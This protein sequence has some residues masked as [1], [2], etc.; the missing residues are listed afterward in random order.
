EPE[1]RYKENV[2][3]GSRGKPA[4]VVFKD[5]ETENDLLHAADT[6]NEGNMTSTEIGELVPATRLLKKK[7][8]K[9]NLH[10]PLGNRVVFDDEGNKLPPLATIAD[11]QSC[12]G[13]SLFDPGMC[14]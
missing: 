4:T 10:R 11:P 6:S 8:L 2:L 9:I 12:K 13:T 14:N 7:K 3:E 1:D 5:E